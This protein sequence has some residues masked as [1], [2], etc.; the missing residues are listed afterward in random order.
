[1]LFAIIAVLL[2]V[3]HP[4]VDKNDPT[5]WQTTAIVGAP[6][7]NGIVGTGTVSIGQILFYGNS[8]DVKGGSVY[9]AKTRV[10]RSR[11][12]AP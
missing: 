5:G 8:F 1:M 4:K 6:P 2:P 9:Q 12:S 11:S 10:L 7:A 3:S